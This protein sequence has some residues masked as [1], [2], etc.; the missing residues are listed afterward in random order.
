MPYFIG[1]IAGIAVFGIILIVGIT[2]Y[3]RRRRMRIEKEN[4]AK[5]MY[6]CNSNVTGV[7]HNNHIS[8]PVPSN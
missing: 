3:L 7:S 5:G 6:D 1:V 2:L 8:G 4:E